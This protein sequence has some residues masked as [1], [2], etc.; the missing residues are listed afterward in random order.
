MKNYGCVHSLWAIALAFTS[1]L[2]VSTL[3]QSRKQHPSFEILTHRMDVDVDGAPN[4]YGPPGK[5]KVSAPEQPNLYHRT[6]IN[7]PT[8]WEVWLCGA[9]QLIV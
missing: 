8:R 7:R 9:A 1:G 6:Y 4:A 2:N 5:Q 3:A